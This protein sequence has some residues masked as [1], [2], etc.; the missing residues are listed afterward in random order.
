ML[1][2]LDTRLSRHSCLFNLQAMKTIT[3]EEFVFK[4]E[5][6]AT[7]FKGLID[8]TRAKMI[9]KTFRKVPASHLGFRSLFSISF[10]TISV[11][12]MVIMTVTTMTTIRTIIITTNRL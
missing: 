12:T 1:E 9:P 5:I 4:R 8:G 10:R 6:Q 7:R 2:S 3:S 11:I